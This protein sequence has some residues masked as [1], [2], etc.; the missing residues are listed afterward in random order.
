M[1]SDRD[2]LIEAAK[3][4]RSRAHAPYSG[5][6]V[7]AALIDES[8][9]LHVGCNVENSSF[10]EGTCAEAGAIAAMVA[11]GGTR[12][13]AIACIGGRD[14]LEDC[15]PCGGC[16]QRI[17]E[18]ADEHTRVILVNGD[19]EVYECGIAELLPSGFRLGT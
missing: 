15:T 6:Y 19:G 8:G 13:A 9:K 16:R 1:A 2:Q 5:F 10:P 3:R 18:F 17:N 7:G 4:V 12:I 11:T 14:E